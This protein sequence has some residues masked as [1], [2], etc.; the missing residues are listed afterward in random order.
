[1]RVTKAQLVQENFELRNKLENMELYLKHVKA[2]ER[3]LWG[4]MTDEFIGILD[5]EEADKDGDL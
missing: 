2:V 4:A 3:G 5:M 1:M